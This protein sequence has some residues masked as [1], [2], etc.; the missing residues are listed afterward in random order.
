[1]PDTLRKNL[2]TLVRDIIDAWVDS[3]AELLKRLKESNRYDETEHG[4]L[5]KFIAR[6]PADFGNM[7]VTIDRLTHSA[8]A[9]TGSLGSDRQDFRTNDCDFPVVRNARV[10]I[11]LRYQLPKG[12]ENEQNLADEVVNALFDAGPCLDSSF[13]ESIGEPVIEERDTRPGEKGHIG[14]VATITVNIECQQQG[15]ALLTAINT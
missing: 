6:A 12:E 11:T 4:Y 7:S 13:V 15:R 1:M 2:T 3:R 8:W 9:R 10:I 14:K 5:R